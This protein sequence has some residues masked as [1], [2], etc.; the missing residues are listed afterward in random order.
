MFNP[1]QLMS[2]QDPEASFHLPPAS[3]TAGEPWPCIVTCFVFCPS[4][5]TRLSNVNRTP[6]M[7]LGPGPVRYRRSP[8]HLSIRRSHY[9]TVS[10]N[11]LS[12]VGGL[13]WLKIP[14]SYPHAFRLP[15]F[16]SH[17]VPPSAPRKPSS[18]PT[19]RLEQVPLTLGSVASF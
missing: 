10:P 17:G 18:L 14:L 3:G 13:S 15:A 2:R 11:F 4:D 8:P 16:R 6:P 9:C 1:G 12:D 7:P 19:D 5:C